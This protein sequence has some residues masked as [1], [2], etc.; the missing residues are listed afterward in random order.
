ML[1]A[2]VRRL[3]TTMEPSK[4]P[5][6]LIHDITGEV[7]HLSQIGSYFTDRAVYG[8]MCAPVSDLA[9]V[10]DI[11]SLGL[12]YLPLVKQILSLHSHA[13]PALIGG[14]SFGCRIAYAV[15]EHLEREGLQTNLILLDGSIDGPVSLQYSEI[16][17][18]AT[19]LYVQAN[20]LPHDP[21]HLA[22]ISDL[23][24][25][26]NEIGQLHVKGLTSMRSRVHTLARLTRSY[27]TTHST[28]A[29]TLRILSQ[30]P[31]DV[32]STRNLV[33][34]LELVEVEGEHFDFFRISA[35]EVAEAVQ[36]FISRHVILSDLLTSPTAHELAALSQCD[37]FSV[38]YEGIG[39][40]EWTGSMES[41]LLLSILPELRE[42]VQLSN[43]SISIDLDAR[44]IQLLP[45]DLTL[46]VDVSSS[47]PTNLGQVSSWMGNDMLRLIPKTM[48]L[49]NIDFAN[50]EMALSPSS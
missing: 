37:Q 14:Y 8:V 11:P 12:Q 2:V 3:N 33:R 42:A 31:P 46:F 32:T 48:H 49:K 7:S 4:A 16:D 39:R 19:R 50:K 24:D 43:G 13:A 35:H 20:A 1:P 26:S 40:V 17:A 21:G 36:S 47:L 25:L 15:S 38:K 22:A 41:S 5:L 45:A 9:S 23:S 30:S 27:T 18:F 29:S 6:I 44:C 28:A 34:D 10:Q